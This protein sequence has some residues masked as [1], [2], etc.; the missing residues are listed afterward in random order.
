MKRLVHAIEA[1]I[2]ALA[3]PAAASYIYLPWHD[4]DAF[5]DELVPAATFA[6]D[7]LF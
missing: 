3:S 1:R 4:P 6:H 7:F 5:P 2:Q